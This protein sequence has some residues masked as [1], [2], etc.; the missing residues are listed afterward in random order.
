MSSAMLRMAGEGLRIANR[1][2]R[3]LLALCIDNILYNVVQ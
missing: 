3:Q 2:S 1:I